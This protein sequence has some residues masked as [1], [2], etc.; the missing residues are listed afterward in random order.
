MYVYV[1]GK[2]VESKVITIDPIGSD[3]KDYV[4]KRFNSG[5]TIT[6]TQVIDLRE[7]VLEIEADIK[8]GRF[9]T[10]EDIISFAERI[11]IE[12]G[13][14]INVISDIIKAIF[15][16]GEGSNHNKLIALERMRSTLDLNWIEVLK[17]RAKRNNRVI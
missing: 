2:L 13:Y 15:K 3:V 17:A 8:N 12:L 14:E 9:V 10:D 7:G 11:E 5:S 6:E 4:V 16:L 1:K